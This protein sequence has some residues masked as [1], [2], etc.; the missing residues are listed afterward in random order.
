[1][2]EEANGQATEI[3]PIRAREWG[4]SGRVVAYCRGKIQKF[5]LFFFYKILFIFF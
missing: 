3:R 1:M 5:D 4:Q 2:G